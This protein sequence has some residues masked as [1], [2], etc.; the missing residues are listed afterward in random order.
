MP[1]RTFHG[2]FASLTR[3]VRTRLAL[4][5]LLAISV[6]ASTVGAAMAEPTTA[7][8]DAE[9]G[10]GIAA[11]LDAIQLED[12]IQYSPA[13]KPGQ[14]IRLQGIIGRRTKKWIE[15]KNKD[16]RTVQIPLDAIT[17]W[18]RSGYVKNELSS[19]YLGGPTALAGLALLSAGVGHNDPKMASLLE[20]LIA[21]PNMQSGTY[22]HSL[23]A[24]MLSALLDRNLSPTTRT[25][26]ALLLR[27]EVNWLAGAGRGNGGYGYTLDDAPHWDH[28]NT[29]FANLG[30]WAG[31]LADVGTKRS[32]WSLMR[33]HWLTSQTDSGGWSYRDNNSSPTSSMT[34]AGCNSLFIVLD[35]YFPLREGRY[36]VFEGIPPNRKAREA[37]KRVYDAILRGDAFL[38]TNPPDVSQHEGYELFGLERLGLASGRARIGGVDWYASNLKKI[39]GCEWGRSVVADSFALIFLAH[40]QAP[41]FIQKMQYGADEDQWNY[42]Y[43]DLAGITRFLSKSFERLYRWQI[44]GSHATLDELRD[45]PIL[46]LSGSGILELPED[47]LANIRAYIDDGGVV[48]LHA[49]RASGRFTDSAAKLFERMFRDRGYRFEVLPED[50]PVFHCHF[51]GPASVWERRPPL[52]GMSDGSR[53]AV[54][55]CPVDIAGAWHQ[56]RTRFVDL[57]R[58]F[59][60]LRVYTA[61]PYQ[62]LPRRM[63]DGPTAQRANVGRARVSV[64]TFKH[65]GEWDRHPN[66]WRRYG[67]G[68]DSRC[69]ISIDDRGI[70]TAASAADRSSLP[71]V[72]HV[73]VPTAGGPTEAEAKFLI[74]A[75][76]AGTVVLIDAADGMSAGISAVPQWVEALN[77]G[78]RE[79]LAQDH[80]IATG[81]FEGGNRLISLQTTDA[82]ASLRQGDAAPPIYLR[83]IENRVALIACP[84]DLSAGMDRHF[85]WNRVGYLPESTNQIMDNILLW[86]LEQRRGAASNER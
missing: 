18:N 21:E 39:L 46:Y 80:P 58:I 26:N 73:K 72:L 2:C 28:S 42:Y 5:W 25:K 40:G 70:I 77:F 69:G 64:G 53:V 12:D 86:T 10:Q 24:A 78:R 31:A 36:V 23:R 84:F 85:I 50:H 65:A 29:Q 48:F 9:I 17:V 74:S 67:S 19:Y 34:L 3:D 81:A 82:G 14:T 11:L 76:S 38:T 56:E 51:G 75:M 44:V 35:R 49:D 71:D 68:S 4:G 79:V 32:V 55:L 47:T 54:F 30:L 83:T 1:E 33:D 20:T 37:M 60:N 8:V 13:G 16:G 27:R 52:R 63:P 59:V 6:S 41:I 62:Q 66:T 61:P 43:R 7:D 45:A 22:V 15:I 57:F